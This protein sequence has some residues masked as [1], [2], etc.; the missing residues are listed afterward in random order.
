MI[1]LIGALRRWVG[2]L[3]EE[4][5]PR[6]KRDWGVP[7]KSAFV[8]WSLDIEAVVYKYIV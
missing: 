2:K 1:G 6:N 3:V 7:N 8:C 4:E 5:P